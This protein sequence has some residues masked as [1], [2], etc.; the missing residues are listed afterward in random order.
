MANN[1]PAFDLPINEVKGYVSD[2]MVQIGENVTV[3]GVST[4]IMIADLERIYS[5][6]QQNMK[7]T[8]F[9]YDTTVTRGSRVN[10]E[11][12][13]VAIVYNN[14]NDDIVSKS[15]QILI[16][17]SSPEIYRYGEVYDTNR[18]SPTYGD[19]ISK[20]LSLR[21]T[22]YGF[23]ERLTAKEKQFDVGLLHDAILRF[24]TFKSTDTDLG[25]IFKY[26][27]KQYRVI[28]VDDIT[29][30]ILVIQL[31]SVRE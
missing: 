10:F 23:I 8:V 20:G 15:A 12:G 28:D 27:G 19:I 11:D 29:E 18:K 14:P 21:G 24:V 5:N 31:A 7:N 2:L 25:D 13:K 16:C 4:K 6:L 22:A 3:D 26:K 17:N 9:L 1:L 30:G